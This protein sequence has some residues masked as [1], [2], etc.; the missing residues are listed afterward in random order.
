MEEYEYLKDMSV[1][2]LV[3]IIRKMIDFEETEKALS[4][5]KRRDP[6]K[7]LELGIDIIKNNKGDDYL[8]A[9]AWGIL[10]FKNKERMIQVLEEREAN[11]EKALLDDVIKD[12]VRCYDELKH[13]KGTPFA[14]RIK[15]TYEALSD[16]ERS[17]MTW[18]KY[19]EF[20]DMYLGPESLT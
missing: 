18:N 3:D 1:N 6:G 16:Y 20:C 13:L 2:E 11:I 12:M 8:Q 10:F 19:R 5:L 14:E 9:I 15:S 7:A 4:I 17:R